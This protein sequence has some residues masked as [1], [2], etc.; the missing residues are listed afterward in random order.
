MLSPCLQCVF[1]ICVLFW[2][3]GVCGGGGLVFALLHP[4]VAV[5]AVAVCGILQLAGECEVL[6]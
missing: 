1:L 2:R 6:Q 5:R 3:A 4:P